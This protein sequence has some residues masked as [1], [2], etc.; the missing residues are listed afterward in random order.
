MMTTSWC[1]FSC[2][3][4]TVLR[5]PQGGGSDN[6][7]N[8]WDYLGLSHRPRGYKAKKVQKKNKLQRMLFLTSVAIYF[9]IT[10]Y[11]QGQLGQLG[12]SQKNAV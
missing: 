6:Y 8:K 2:G 7:L 9:I 10:E 3:V 5:C 11:P 12:Q 1:L 4:P